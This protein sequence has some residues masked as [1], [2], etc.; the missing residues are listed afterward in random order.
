LYV[1]VELFAAFQANKV[2]YILLTR[3]VIGR[4]LSDERR[5]RAV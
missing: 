4:F 3:Y 1:Y 2:V 5:K